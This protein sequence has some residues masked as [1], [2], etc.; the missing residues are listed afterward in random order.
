MYLYKLATWLNAPM[1][2]VLSS[3]VVDSPCT[4]VF[5]W[6]CQIAYN[7][8]KHQQWLVDCQKKKEDIKKSWPTKLLSGTQPKYPPLLPFHLFS[9]ALDSSSSIVATTLQG[10]GRRLLLY[11]WLWEHFC[12]HFQ[13][14]NR[15]ICNP[16]STLYTKTKYFVLKT[17]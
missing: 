15:F 9:Y 1:T 4:C 16:L 2:I 13:K 14:I 7:F 8:C 17:I 12:L 6:V 10:R 3:V 5:F 11:P